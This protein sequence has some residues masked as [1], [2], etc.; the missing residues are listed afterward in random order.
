MRYSLAVGIAGPPMFSV[1]PRAF[2]GLGRFAEQGEQV[3]ARDDGACDDGALD[4]AGGLHETSEIVA[5]RPLERPD[6]D[7][8]LVELGPGVAFQ[9]VDLLPVRRRDGEAAD[10]FAG[11]LCIAHVFSSCVRLVTTR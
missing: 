8:G 6:A 7:L 5:D 1:A 9:L 2:V 10:A 3:E 4:A 11:T